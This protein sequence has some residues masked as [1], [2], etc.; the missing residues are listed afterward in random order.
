MYQGIKDSKEK[1]R[2]IIPKFAG[3]IIKNAEINPNIAM[4]LL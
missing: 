3:I 4:N 2:P 1:M